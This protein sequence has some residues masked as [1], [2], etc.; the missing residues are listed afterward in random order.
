MWWLFF[1][2]IQIDD[3][4]MT[5]E[6]TYYRKLVNNRFQFSIPHLMACFQSWVPLQQSW[7][8]TTIMMIMVNMTLQLMTQGHNKIKTCFW[9]NLVGKSWNWHSQDSKCRYI[10]GQKVSSS[11]LSTVM[12]TKDCELVD[13]GADQRQETATLERRHYITAPGLEMAQLEIWP[14]GVY[15]RTSLGARRKWDQNPLHF[16]KVFQDHSILD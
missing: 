1:N 9:S 15:F 16:P 13:T 14:Q 10:Y 2:S 11:I 7:L 8:A 5:V 6:K 12:R 3:R 4:W